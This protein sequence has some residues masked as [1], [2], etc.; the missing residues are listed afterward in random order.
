MDPESL[1][2]YGLVAHDPIVTAHVHCLACGATNK[3]DMFVNAFFQPAGNIDFTCNTCGLY[4]AASVQL[5]PDDPEKRIG[6][7]F[8]GEWPNQQK[9]AEVPA[10]PEEAQPTA[11]IAT[12]FEEDN[13]ERLI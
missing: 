10:I 9:P 6:K 8:S 3:L 11:N 2:T 13:S 4:I 7:K 1:A 5:H 12:P